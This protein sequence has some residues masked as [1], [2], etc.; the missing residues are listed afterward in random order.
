MENRNWLEIKGSPSAPYINNTLLP[1]ASHAEQYFNPPRLHPSLPN[2][3]WLEAGNNFGIFNDALPD[4]NHQSTTNHLVTLLNNAGILWKSYQEDIGGNVCPLTD[5]AQYAPKHNPMVYFDDVTSR[6]DP[7][8]QYCIAHVR[9]YTELAADLQSSNVGRYNFITPNLCHDMHDCPTADGDTWLS[10]ELPKILNSQVYKDGGAIFITWD[11][12]E[13]S[14]GPI[15]MIVV[16]PLA[17]G[18]GYSNE[19]HYTHS[20]TLRTM[21]EIFGVTPLLGDAANATDLSDL[22]AAPIP[23]PTPSPS[24]TPTPTPTLSNV[25]VTSPVNENDTAALSGNISDLNAGDPLTLTVNWGDGSAPQTFNYAAGTTSFNEPH[26]YLDDKP[27]GTA[28]D[29]YIINLTLNDKHGGTAT[30]ATTIT[31][32]NVA[33]SMVNL[34]LSANPIDENDTVTLNGSFTDPGTQDTHAVA[35]SWGDG[36]PNTTLNLAAGILTFS[37]THQYTKSGNFTIGITATDD[38]TGTGT[39]STGISVNTPAPSLQ[40]STANFRVDEGDGAAPITVT[41]TGDTTTAVSVDFDTSDGSASQK[42]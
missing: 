22:F 3:L 42:K 18:G 5:N 30:A 19:I 13:G 24:P 2:Y 14:D 1:M 32:N 10:E 34:S 7:N 20:S 38:D 31:V 8:S 29:N 15:G 26:K 25:V 27:K 28:S 33:P 36:S 6:N 40:F 37:T 39:A 4:V 16:S 41:R 12:G 21:E 35:I 17:K 11:E 23:T 9:P